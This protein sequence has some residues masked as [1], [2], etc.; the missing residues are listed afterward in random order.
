MKPFAEEWGGSGQIQ[1]TCFC[2]ND[3]YTEGPMSQPKN[4]ELIHCI[5]FYPGEGEM[6]GGS[7]GL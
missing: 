6:D 7:E 5:S 3:S 2:F 4:T 1:E